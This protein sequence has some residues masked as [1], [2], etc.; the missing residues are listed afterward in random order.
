[1]YVFVYIQY[2]YTYRQIIRFIQPRFYQE[3][4]RGGETIV[5]VIF[6][7]QS[8]HTNQSG[9]HTETYPRREN[10]K[11]GVGGWLNFQQ[12]QFFVG[13]CLMREGERKSKNSP[14]FF[15]SALYT[16]NQQHHQPSQP[17]SQQ[18]KRFTWPGGLEGKVEIVGSG[19]GGREKVV[20]M[21][22][23][24]IF[25]NQFESCV[26]LRTLFLGHF[27]IDFL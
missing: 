24:V 6:T 2:T 19:A 21:V 22:G 9:A 18:T 3:E 11:G 14:P 16:Y 26:K 8:S 23:K 25:F 20:E 4:D 12:R 13:K 17:S 15:P 10:F 5:C 1:M 7:T 27:E